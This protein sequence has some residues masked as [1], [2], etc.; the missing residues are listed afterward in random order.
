VGKEEINYPYAGRNG[1]QEEC[2]GNDYKL[3]QFAA[4]TE[5][6]WKRISYIQ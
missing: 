5:S 4:A 6:K 3:V 1:L 2:N